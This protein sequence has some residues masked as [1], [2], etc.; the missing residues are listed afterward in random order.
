MVVA[1]DTSPIS[2]IAIIGRLNLLRSQFREIWIPGAVRSELDELSH[3]AA[4]K[5]I[6]QALQDGWI[7]PQ[8]LRG[9]KVARLLAAA[10]DPGEDAFHFGV[11]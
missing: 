9:D 4:L 7:K 3:P 2:N 8:V 1:S 6:Q 11:I 10:L 5:E